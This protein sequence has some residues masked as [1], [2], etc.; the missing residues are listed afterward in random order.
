MCR[1]LK[2]RIV[3]SLTTLSLAIARAQC[4]AG[5]P[6]GRGNVLVIFRAC[7]VPHPNLCMMLI[8]HETS[9]ELQ[10]G[11]VL[12]SSYCKVGI[13]S[14]WGQCCS[15]P[16]R[17]WCILCVIGS[18]MPILCFSSHST[19]IWPM[20]RY[21]YGE[22]GSPYRKPALTFLGFEKAALLDLS[23]RFLQQDCYPVL[24]WGRHP[25]FARL[26]ERIKYAPQKIL[27]F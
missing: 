4:F 7:P 23:I 26:V 24:E 20:K 3:A 2:L 22:T 5:C 19:R 13:W 1:S 9:I 8:N 27:E 18:L 17:W 15:P 25:L 21:K 6:M 16:W 11:T 12:S 14:S 10:N